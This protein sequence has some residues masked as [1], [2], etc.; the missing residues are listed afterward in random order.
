MARSTRAIA[1][2]RVWVICFWRVWKVFSENMALGHNDSEIVLVTLRTWGGGQY[3]PMVLLSCIHGSGSVMD[4][5]T[6]ELMSAGK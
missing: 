1:I 4:L 6:E 3:F 5:N 2:Q